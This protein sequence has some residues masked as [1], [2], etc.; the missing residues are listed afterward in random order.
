MIEKG[1]ETCHHVERERWQGRG[2]EKKGSLLW[3]FGG[4]LC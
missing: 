4:R 1:F 2:V 3:V